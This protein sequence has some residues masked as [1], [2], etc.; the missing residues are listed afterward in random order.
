MEK[1]IAFKYAD[2]WL[3]LSIIYANRKDRAILSNII[4][5]GD[6]INHAIFTWEELQGG[7]FRLINTGYVVEDS[8][9]Y[10]PTDKTIVLYRE[11][12]IKTKSPLK[13][14]VFIRE[15]L[16]S[17]EWSE[18]YNPSTANAGITYERINE[19]VVEA[20]YLEYKRSL[21]GQGIGQGIGIPGSELFLFWLF[22]TFAA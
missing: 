17:P 5:Y 2:A 19:K 11:F 22:Y 4:A 21:V 15:K 16:S 14:L 9:G 18:D 3:L 8:E 13:Q 10:K 1:K 6:F 7:L 12:S 20:A